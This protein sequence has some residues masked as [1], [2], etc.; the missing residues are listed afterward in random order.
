MSEKV[1]FV[2]DEPNVLAGYERQLRKR[3][4]IET[5]NGGDAALAMMAARGPYSVIVSD[6]RMPGMD[7][8]QLLTRARERHP[9]IVR[10][11]LTGNTDVQHAIDAVNRGSLF[12]FLTKP[13]PSE[14]LCT[15]LDAAL[16]QYRLVTAEREL[17]DKTLRGSLQVL[18]EVLALANPTA[19]G[20]A[21][22]AQKLIRDLAE[23]I[24]GAGGWEIDVAAVLSQLGCIALPESVLAA[25]SRGAELP[26]DERKQLESHPIVARDL[27]RPIPRLERVVEIIAYQDKPFLAPSRPSLEKCGKDIPL[28]A[29][30]L[31]LA[32]DFD[33]LAARGI[34]KPQAVSHLESRTGEYDPELLA[35]LTSLIRRD[36]AVVTL[37]VTIVDLEAGMTLAEDLYTD[38]GVLLLSKGN[39]I[40][41]ALKRRLET[42]IIQGRTP[43]LIRVQSHK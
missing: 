10:M 1:L 8:V 6:L 20:R 15:A 23:A 11:L 16:A 3:Y 37:E 18:G 32:L 38:S 22:R 42:T 12:R 14:T 40:T 2:D 30:L 27:L 34:P 26:L 7:G 24:D 41:G 31:K 4:A 25:A 28:G 17:L 5:A 39:P 29:R 33:S 36:T 9:D 19:F 43:K 13:C 35:A 21:L